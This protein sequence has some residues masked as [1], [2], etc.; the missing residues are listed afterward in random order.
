MNL[1][2][3]NIIFS[4][5]FIQNLYSQ[6]VDITGKVF[7][8]TNHNNVQD[9]GEKGIPNV[10]ISDQISTSM[11]DENGNYTFSASKTFPYIFI[12]LPNGYS[13]KFFHPIA[14]EVNFPLIQ[15]QSQNQIKFIHA[16]DTHMDS[17][18]LPRM[19]R[20]REMADSLNVDFIIITGDL[21]RDALRVNEK[22]A[23]EY[24]QMY[25]NEI[26]KFSIPVFSGV[27]NHELFGIERDKSLVSSK[28]ELYGKK[29]YRKFI[30][31]DYYSFNFGGIH[32]ISIDGV[33]FQNL[34]YFGGV[35]SIQLDW[36]ERDL[37]YVD[38]ETPIVTFN[39]IP[40]VSPGFTFQNF[41]NHIFYGP[42]LL[43][44]NNVLEHRHIVYNFDEVKKRI[45]GRPY[46]LA[47]SG[48]YHYAQEGIIIGNE[49]KFAQTSA[50]T[51]PDQYISNG[52][53]V[54]SGFTLYEIK[55]GKILN[56]KFIPLNFPQN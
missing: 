41:E 5:L 52:F 11:T 44:Q 4:L 15:N 34:Y 12:S 31:P 29:M 2:W 24:F 37:A 30:G 48:H 39:H 49:T 23:S 6:D 51:R 47:L 38:Q 32:F 13:G 46:P 33:D 7:E 56:S 14:S 35:D 36:L 43:L 16:S 26:E 9:I 1:N 54:R 22:T 28:H 45:D 27:G 25:V 53:N 19:Q 20:F 18:N 10:V 21:I 8:D 50:I 17:L 55:D 3:F 40:F 42:Q